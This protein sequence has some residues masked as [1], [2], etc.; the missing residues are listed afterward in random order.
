MALRYT[1]ATEGRKRAAV[2]AARIGRSG[3]CH[4]PATN[5]QR[6]DLLAAVSG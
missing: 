6:P 4:N 2:E 1:L 5:D 3:V